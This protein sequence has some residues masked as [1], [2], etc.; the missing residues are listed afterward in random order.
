[1]KLLHIDASIRGSHSVSRTVTAAIV[2]KL[3][4]A[5]PGIEAA[6]RDLIATPPPHMTFA[7]LPD[8]HPS[9]VLAGPLSPAQRAIR[10][11][12]QKILEEFMAADIVVLGAPMYNWSLPTQLKSW[13]D[14]IIV[15][16]RTFTYGRFGPE[17]GLVGDKRVI[18]VST[19]GLF[20]GPGARDA[21]A[22][23]SETY[24]RAV[25]SFLGVNNPEFVIAEGVM[26]GEEN[27]TKAISSAMSA[28]EQL[29][30]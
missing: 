29:A 22:E 30:A 28:V 6:Y 18:V 15:P 5:N 13:L 8:D 23:H 1:M 19:R 14:I 2:N 12:S 24:L 27:K 11:E 20:Y 9:S 7:T 4:R 16:G 10:N 3:K 17:R 21:Y 26:A 25:L